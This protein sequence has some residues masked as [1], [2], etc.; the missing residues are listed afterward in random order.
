MVKEYYKVF[1]IE[2]L[3]NLIKTAKMD[4]CEEN[5]RSKASTVVLRFKES[6]KFEGQLKLAGVS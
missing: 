1:D 2:E 3:E 4:S 6:E 5:I